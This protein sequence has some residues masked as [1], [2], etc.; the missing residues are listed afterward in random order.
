MKKKVLLLVP[1]L[2]LTSCN[3]NE[4]QHLNPYEL[5]CEIQ[6]KVYYDY[7]NYN[8]I[9]DYDSYS[10]FKESAVENFYDLSF[11]TL[12]PKDSINN[13]NSIFKIAYNHNL[14]PYD[15]L[16]Y[17]VN[18]NIHFVEKYVISNDEL[19]KLDNSTIINSEDKNKIESHNVTIESVFYPSTY[20]EKEYSLQ[21]DYSYK[22]MRI[23][24]EGK[25]STLGY[26]Y[27]NCK[28]DSVV[29]KDII[30]NYVNSNLEYHIKK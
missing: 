21:I 7:L 5:Y 24:V 14:V 6:N 23:K 18:S 12:N 9:D 22:Y 1:F 11:Y 28:I 29:Y 8:V 15:K 4:I 17:I 20:D 30:I 26:I 25:Y 10:N 16:S 27:T 13:E 3:S 19:L 2:L